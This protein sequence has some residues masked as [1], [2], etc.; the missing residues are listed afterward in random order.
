MPKLEIEQ[1]PCLSDN[2]AVLL[3][4]SETNLTACVDAPDAGEI[5]KHLRDK[6]WQLDDLLI[7]HHHADHTQG[8]LQIKQAT[9]CTVIGP[10]A[11]ADRIPGIDRG[12]SEGDTIPFGD[13]EISV[14]ETPGHTLG[15]VAYW[16]PS[17]NVVFVGDTLFSM[18]SGRVFEGNAEMMWGSLKK[19]MAL[20]RETEIYCGHEYTAANA[21]FALTL[22]PDNSALH[23]RAADVE[24]LRAAGKPTLP[25]RLDIEL[26]TNPFLRVASDAIRQ[27][28]GLPFAPD[29]RVFAAVR[30]L[31]NK[32]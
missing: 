6:G 4:D 29:W 30:E 19:L 17:A 8:V 23:A 3:H 26:E 25:S 15:H 13:F 22:E 16:I 1:F 18:G 21:R 5:L 20:P 14:I 31:K 24:R 12:V 32:A 11:E 28:V 10:Q 2:Y 27:K 7:T 9:A